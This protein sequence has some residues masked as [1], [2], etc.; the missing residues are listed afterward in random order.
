MSRRHTRPK[1]R[2]W[3]LLVISTILLA[4]AAAMWVTPVVAQS[5][6]LEQQE[7]DLIQQFTLPD[8][9][10]QRPV[11]RPR[12]SPSAP[13]RPARPPSQPSSRPSRSSSRPSS[14]PSSSRSAS[15]AK[16]APSPQAASTPKPSESEKPASSAESSSAAD[17]IYQY[18]L[19][20]SRS[21]VVGNRLRLE[22]VY[23][24]TQLGFTRPRHWDMQS[25]KAIVRY[26]HSPALL[27]DRSHLTLRINNT[28]VGS[29]PLD[30]AESQ[31]AEAVFDIPPSLIQDYNNLSL[32]AVQHTSETCT[33]PSN[34]AIWTEVLPDSKLLFDFKTEAV[35][36]DL[37]QFPY[38]F[39]DPLS[40]DPNRIAYL[41]PETYT[42]DWASAAARFQVA[43][44]RMAK[45][46]PLDTQMVE[47]VDALDWGDHLLVI[48]TPQ[49]QPLLSALDL[50][51]TLKDDRILDG[52]D[53][54]LPDDAGLLI[55][56]T[57]QDGAVPALI[58]T[59]NAPAGIEKAIRLLSQPTDRQL[60]TGQTLVVSTVSDPV[61][62]ADQDWPGY[63][64][65]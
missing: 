34:P 53:T 44:A 54:P 25:A 43:A 5:S 65:R 55:L 62:S 60:L 61:V 16:P 28:S 40:L 13:S 26:Q 15:P 31:I 30:R 49:E 17:E 9:P 51:F 24:E 33:N 18:V 36:L 56:T 57:V 58:V 32:V 8:T 47:D 19:D 12:P 7:N 48:G 39:I 21:P 41:A 2:L 23:P 46:Q 45:F 11:Y 42:D 3:P 4:I 37:S 27:G 35:P 14:A 6:A 63:L 22:G 20:F 64:P 10:R 38:P 29:V 59:G 1:R 52:D 50:P